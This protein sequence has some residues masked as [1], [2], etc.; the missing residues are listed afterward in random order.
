MIFLKDFFLSK[1]ELNLCLE[2][3]ESLLMLSKTS[4]G[5]FL[6][7]Y[8]HENSVLGVFSFLSVVVQ[9]IRL[10]ETAETGGTSDFWGE[11]LV[12]GVGN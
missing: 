7:F 9:Q 2:W 8:H 6:S 4:I 5:L 12:N 11:T 10:F 3:S 1:K